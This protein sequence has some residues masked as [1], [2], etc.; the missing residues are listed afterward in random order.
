M[1]GCHLS[2]CECNMVSSGRASLFPPT[3]PQ[4]ELIPSYHFVQSG[5][6][7]MLPLCTPALV[8]YHVYIPVIIVFLPTQAKTP[9]QWKESGEKVEKSPPCMG[10]G[11]R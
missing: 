1:Y 11:G 10:G 3:A 8:R 9:T 6:I 5:A 2:R 7:S 4:N